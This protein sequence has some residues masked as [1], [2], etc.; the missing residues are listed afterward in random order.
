M[1]IYKFGNRIPYKTAIA[2]GMFDGVHIGHRLL[3]KKTI[4]IAHIRKLTPS[5]YT[6]YN[7]PIKEANRKYI[8]LFEERL[9][10][11]GHFG[12]E[13]VYVAELNKDFMEMSPKTFFK[14]ELLRNANAKS[15]IVGENFRFGINRSGD[16][17]L[18]MTFGKNS[19]T[20]VFSIPLSYHNGKPISSSLIHDLIKNGNVVKANELLNYSF[21]LSGKV[22]SGKGIGRLLGFPTANLSY[23]NGYK[24]LPKRGVYVTIAE[25]D[26]LLYRSVTNVGVNPTFENSQN[27][28]V[29]IHFIDKDINLYG[30]IVRLHFLKR[31]RDEKKFPTT[32]LLTEQIQK[33][34]SYAK[35]LFKKNNMVKSI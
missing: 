6:F 26:G 24:V 1:K 33:D 16:A 23:F 22:V 8:T 30:K 13:A 32:E 20:D 27:I 34:I 17:K 21:F 25:V 2:V 4:E 15:I 19:N 29:E 5:V 35:N 12:I 18:M 9:S 11:L 10:L 3:I 14:I 28:K 31:I 7:H